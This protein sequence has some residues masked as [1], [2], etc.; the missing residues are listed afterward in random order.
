MS[1]HGSDEDKKDV[2]LHTDTMDA[3]A[4]PQLAPSAMTSK[5]KALALAIAIGGFLFGE[6]PFRESLRRSGRS[7]VQDDRRFYVSF[8]KDDEWM[9]ERA[10]AELEARVEETEE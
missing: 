5:A 8:V 1:F 6:F 9:E 7:R 2:A 10:N 3:H 4:Q